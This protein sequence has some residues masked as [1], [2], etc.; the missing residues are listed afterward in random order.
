MISVTGLK[1]MFVRGDGRGA[2]RD[3]TEKIGIKL[4]KQHLTCFDGKLS[5]YSECADED[6]LQKKH[7]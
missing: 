6:N 7:A 5:V 1:D 2:A 3:E 4:I